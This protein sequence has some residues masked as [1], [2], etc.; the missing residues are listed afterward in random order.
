MSV[1]A[2]LARTLWTHT[3]I[4]SAE[5]APIALAAC[6][7]SQLGIEAETPQK[8]FSG[9]AERLR[10]TGHA[11]ALMRV[12]G[13]LEDADFEEAQIRGLESLLPLQ[14]P[15]EID[16][17]AELD[18][19]VD[20]ARYREQFI[21]ISANIGGAIGAALDIPAGDTIACL[22]S[23][24]ATIA[25][26]LARHR[27]VTLHISNWRTEIIMALLAFADG[28]PLRV[29]RR[30]PIETIPHSDGSFTFG[31]DNPPRAGKYDHLISVPSLGYRMSS[32]A[33]A[34]MLFEVWQV[35]QLGHRARKSFIT[36]LTDGVLFRESRNEVAFREQLCATSGLTITSLPPGIFGRASGVQVNL[37]KIDQIDKF[38]VVFVDSRTME[39]ISRSGRE[40][41][42]LVVRQIERLGS[43]P[44]RMVGME[45]LAAANF[46]LLPSR[47]VV[48]AEVA[49][50]DEALAERQ[51]VRLGDIAGI[52]RP[53][54][55]Q[56]VRGGHRDD[57][58][59]CLE[60]AVGDISDGRAGV[61]SKEVRFP[62]KEGE[63][64]GKVMV[65]SDDI[66]I[67]IKGNVGAVGLVDSHRVILDA[68]KGTPEIVSQSLAIIRL[69]SGS[70]IK[71]PRLLAAI[72]ASPQMRAKLQAMAAGTTVPALPIKAVQDLAVPLPNEAELTEIQT[73]IEELDAMQADIDQRIADRRD[74]QDALWR[75]FWN[76]PS[77]QDDA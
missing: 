7:A 30:N 24:S 51:T 66:L 1:V 23:G 60:I 75:E 22:N 52:I 71:S 32:G 19:L 45:E 68:T 64:I 42:D 27:P 67:S 50:M 38:G 13:W 15:A 36:L 8:L 53:R 16:W 4:R 47:Y 12:R 74:M 25:W 57:D 44:S 48:S 69:E 59:I 31:A 21:P 10:P 11:D 20:E 28:R 63:S 29:D 9:L 41:E 73:R 6:V 61:P 76:M 43:A 40:Q 54:A 37:L 72:L 62:V 77:D 18:A 3:G 39:R 17:T 26:A 35:E 2:E 58:V 49:R 34:G 5:A 55:P 33:A 46:N 14:V 65:R 70:P 56:P